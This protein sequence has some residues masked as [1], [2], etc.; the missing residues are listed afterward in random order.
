MTRSKTD[1]TA[2]GDRLSISIGVTFYTSV[3]RKVARIHQV[4]RIMRKCGLS[5]S[6]PGKSP[7]ADAVKASVGGLVGAARARLVRMAPS[8]RRFKLATTPPPGSY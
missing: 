2:P 3:T 4:N 6:Y 7:T 5:P 8:A 1:W